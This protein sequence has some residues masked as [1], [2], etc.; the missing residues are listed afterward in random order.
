MDR[1]LEGDELAH[2]RAV[3]E[4]YACDEVQFHALR[5]RRSGQRAFVSVHVVV[6][7]AWSVKEGHDLVERLEVDLRRTLE[8][9]TIT[10]HLEPVEDPASFADATLD[11]ADV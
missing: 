7:G 1:A 5:T 10:T 9:V 6:P 3:L 4:S 11:R 8:P 2:V